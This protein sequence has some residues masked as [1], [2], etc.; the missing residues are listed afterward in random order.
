MRVYLEVAGLHLVYVLQSSAR[1]P[2]TGDE[3]EIPSIWK[4]LDVAK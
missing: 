1:T 3:E 2:T 4:T